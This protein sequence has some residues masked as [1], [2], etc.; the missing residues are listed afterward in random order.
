MD[1][2]DNNQRE[3]IIQQLRDSGC[4]I[5][6][7]RLIILDIILNEEPSCVK[8]IYREAVKLDK[9][10]GS[11]TVYRMVNT[12]EEIGVINRK[13]MYQV[14]CS[15]CDVH[16]SEEDCDSDCIGECA[17]CE[18]RIVVT[19]D[20]D[21]KMVIDRAELQELLEAGLHAK[22]RIAS[23]HKIVRLAM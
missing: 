10:I 22:G 15:N 12:L 19:L 13:N 20:D 3:L 7:Q 9:N 14:D 17:A 23:Q 8:E 16:C 6:K 2:M 4:R 11:A 5:T 21:T 18:T 1:I